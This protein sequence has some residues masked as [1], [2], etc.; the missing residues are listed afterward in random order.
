MSNIR[1]PKSWEIPERLATPES[2]YWS[3]RKVLSALGLGTLGMALPFQGAC[4]PQAAGTGGSAAAGPQAARGATDPA[5]GS[6]FA[7]RFPAKRNPAFTLGDLTLTPEEVSSRYNNFYEFTTTKNRV[8]ELASKYPLPPWTIEVG[9]LVKQPRTL[10]LDALIGKFPLEERLYRFRCVERWAMQVPW[11]GYPLRTLIDHLEPLPSARWVK[12]VTILDKQNMPGQKREPWYPWPYYEGLRL[13]EA[14]HPLAFVVVGSYGHAL[15][16]QHGAPLRLAL[17]WKYGYKS[18]KSIVRIEFTKKRPGTF[19]ND[20]Q[21][22]E[23]GFFSNVDPGKPHPRW[24][25]AEE[26]DIG[27][28]DV[29]RTLLY[30]GY[31]EVA[32]LYNGKEV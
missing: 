27:T 14:R 10:D 16:M 2:I 18:P 25:Q 15:P 6:R 29:R 17:P 24:S 4:A 13:D 20:L 26:T 7:D 8:W 31:P 19:W 3:R 22:S 11:T 9:G 5:I 30:N 23:Y 21:P 32:D 12:F 28:R 1:I